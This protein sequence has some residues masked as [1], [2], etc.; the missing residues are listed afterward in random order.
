MLYE[1]V[2]EDPRAEALAA[3]IRQLFSAQDEQ[4]RAVTPDDKDLLA[5]MAA[6]AAAV[7]ATQRE[8]AGPAAFLD[9][10][11]RV[12]ARFGRPREAAK[13]LIVTP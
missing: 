8:Q 2:P 5:V 13:P 3:E 1:H 9:T 11:A 12:A 4:G 7:D 6:L 10:A